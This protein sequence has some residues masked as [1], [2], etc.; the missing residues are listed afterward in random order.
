MINFYM[1]AYIER[2]HRVS[3]KENSNCLDNRSGKPR[4]TVA[5]LFNFKE[6]EEIM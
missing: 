5:K 6:K 4:T 3:T 1:N 2:A